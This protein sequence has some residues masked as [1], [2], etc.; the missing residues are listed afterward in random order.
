MTFA[1]FA[2]LVSSVLAVGTLN[3]TAAPDA[4]DWD[5][6]LSEAEGQTV[7]WNAW[8]GSTQINAYIDWAGKELK[9]RH[10]IDLVHVKLEDTA[11]AVA[12]L[13]TDQTW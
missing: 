3:A 6:V 11:S 7:Y 9:A 4:S 12:T 8:G 10:G 1:K 13:V 2:T 5:A